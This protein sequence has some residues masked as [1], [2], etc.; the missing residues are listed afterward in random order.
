MAGNLISPPAEFVL[1][2]SLGGD[3]VI[4]FQQV[5]SNGAFLAYASGVTV[6]LDIDTATGLSQAAVVSGHD[7][8]VTVVSA[9]ADLI[10]FGVLW[11]LIVTTPGS[12]ATNV[13]AVNGTVGRFDGRS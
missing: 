2:L 6:T 5:D 1:P 11:R 9:V 8:V 3:L 4:N 13:V 12:P 10:P 7:A